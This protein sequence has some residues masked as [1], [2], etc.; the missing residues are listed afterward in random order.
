MLHSITTSVVYM[1][2][3]YLTLQSTH[4]KH[5]E[6][7]QIPMAVLAIDTIGHLPVTSKGHRWALTATCLHT[8]YM[9]AV[10]MK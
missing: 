10:P 8:L 5:L 7:L 1:L 3:I 4:K 9:F 2:K 6:I